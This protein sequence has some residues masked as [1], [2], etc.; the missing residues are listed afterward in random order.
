MFQ[1]TSDIT[2]GY[3][4]W[5]NTY[6]NILWKDDSLTARGGNHDLII[7]MMGNSCSTLQRGDYTYVREGNSIRVPYNAE[8]LYGYNYCVYKNSNY[9]YSNAWFYAFITGV[10]YINENCTE[11]ALEEDVFQTWA[12][13]C[14]DTNRNVYVERCHV[15]DD[16]LG[17]H[18]LAEP[19]MEFEHEI[20]QQYDIPGLD[21]SNFKV[22]IQT[23]SVPSDFLLGIA[24]YDLSTTSIGGAEYNNIYSGARYF[25]FDMSSDYT[26]D[27]SKWTRALLNAG[28]SGGVT[29]IFMFPSYFLPPVG[30]DDTFPTQYTEKSKE[31]A[32]NSRT[33][34]VSSDLDLQE[35]TNL[36][37][38]GW[39]NNKVYTY[40]YTFLRLGAPGKGHN[41]YR[42]EWFGSP[43]YARFTAYM[44]LDSDTTFMMFPRDYGVNGSTW[45]PGS[46]NFSEG[47]FANMS[48]KCSWTT[49]SYADWSS[50][51]MLGG[52]INA[53]LAVA[54]V[55][56]QVKAIS[57]TAAALAKQPVRAYAGQK[58]ARM[59]PRQTVRSTL[60]NYSDA[61]DMV[62]EAD[63]YHFALGAAGAGNL[64]NTALEANREQ[65][66]PDKQCGTA[67]GNALFAIDA[68][69]P[70]M[71]VMALRY[72]HMEILDRFFD[73]F[74]YQVNLFTTPHITGRPVWNYVKTSG[75]QAVAKKGM[76]MP[77]DAMAAIESVLDSGTT[78]WHVD[79]PDDFGNY[80]LDNTAGVT[81]HSLDGDDA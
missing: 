76:Y 32:V 1:P 26:S 64:M 55:A 18:T 27:L 60:R 20:Y 31:F 65:H 9:S 45:T 78:F 6:R 24:D 54:S 79:N 39:H 8:K 77:T 48:N 25:A 40:P 30:S 3:V 19:S 38:V 44:P 81:G 43:G 13:P 5:D 12:W 33:D 66:I 7:S 57:G 37:G 10:K 52:L 70:L 15:D 69:K 2:L 71:Q 28:G 56:P 16:T 50:Q 42:F 29:N 80:A 53:G 67:S 21:A 73:R 41:D 51:N 4:P 23:A 63:P 62:R 36:Y 34:P 17:R 47:F 72:E 58:T 68:Q 75:M 14:L 35:P 46:L 22:I 59:I 61:A 11:L 49:S 74:G